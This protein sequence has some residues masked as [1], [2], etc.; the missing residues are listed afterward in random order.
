LD[1]RQSDVVATHDGE[2]MFRAQSVHQGVRP[3]E[4]NIHAPAFALDEI[5]A[6]QF[7]ARKGEGFVGEF[8]TQT[9]RVAMNPNLRANISMVR[10]FPFGFENSS[11]SRAENGVAT[12]QQ[13]EALLQRVRRDGT[14]EFEDNLTRVAGITLPPEFVIERQ[15]QVI[16]AAEWQVTGH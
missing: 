12:C 14:V 13:F 16:A 11:G 2:K 9:W 6:K 7:A 15:H 3:E 10:R 1:Y 5:E 8:F 4:V